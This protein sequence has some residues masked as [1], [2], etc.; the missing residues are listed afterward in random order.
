MENKNRKSLK[1]LHALPLALFVW[2]SYSYC[3]D[4]SEKDVEPIISILQNISV[5]IFTIM[6]IWIA[7]LYPNAILRI[8]QPSKVEAIFSEEDDSRVQVIVGVV[9]LSAIVISLLMIGVIAKPFVLKSAFYNAFPATINGVGLFLLLAL[10]YIQLIGIYV[11]IASNI[12]FIIDLKNK[13]NK[14]SLH[15]RL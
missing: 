1:F 5:M 7:Y 15:E 13:K 12:N 8:T 6:G 11:V 4:L 10:S 9:V 14:Q 2:L 3:R